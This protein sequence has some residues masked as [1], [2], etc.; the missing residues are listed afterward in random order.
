MS[1][2]KKILIV[3]DSAVIVKALSLKLSA[4]GYEVLTAPDGGTAV[5]IARQQSPDLLVLDINFP[6]DVAHG[7]G[8]A[9]DGFLI[10]DW[11]KR[12]DV[13]KAIPVI[14]ITGGEPAKYKERALAAGAVS[15]FHKPF[16]PDELLVVIRQILGWDTQTFEKAAAAV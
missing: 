13:A 10:M 4:A 11:L 6:P 5:S 15:F 1:H 7:G 2:K 3:D 14:V 12:M 8:I 9:W 16:Q